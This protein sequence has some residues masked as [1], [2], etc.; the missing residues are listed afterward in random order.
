M[1]HLTWLAAFVLQCIVFYLK[2][3]RFFLLIYFLYLEVLILNFLKWSSLI[4]IWQHLPTAQTQIRISHLPLLPNSSANEAAN[5]GGSSCT[6]PLEAA[7][8]GKGLKREKVNLG[9]V[10]SVEQL[11]C[12]VFSQPQEMWSLWTGGTSVQH[13]YLWQARSQWC[14]S[15]KCSCHIFCVRVFVFG[16]QK[17]VK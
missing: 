9:R 5:L 16:S 7:Q 2:F 14:L 12:C 11:C 17:R 13:Y 4:I 10:L 8:P 3:L 15:V 1:I 6:L